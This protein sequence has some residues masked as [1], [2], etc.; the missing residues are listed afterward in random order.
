[1]PPPLPLPP[2]PSPA[3]SVLDLDLVVS[4]SVGGVSYNV[5]YSNTP[6]RGLVH[7]GDNMDT[8]LEGESAEWPAGGTLDAATY[9]VCVQA[10][11]PEPGQRY[12]I[13]LRVVKDG[14]D[15]LRLARAV[16]PTT[17]TGGD[18][19]PS[20]LDYY[21]SYT[22]AASG[23]TPAGVAPLRFVANWTLFSVPLPPSPPPSP[24]E[25]P[26][27]PPAP[28]IPPDQPMTAS[29]PEPPRPSPKPP[30]PLPPS[31]QPGPPPSPLPP[32]P[33]MPPPLPLPPLPS[34]AV[35]VLDL[36]LVVSWS[37]GGVSYN[38]S[39]S[40]TP[41]RGLVHGGDNMDTG[42]EGESA[43]WPAGGT[44]DA[45]AYHVCVQA[46][47]PEP[48][49]RYNITLRVVKDGVDA[50]SLARAVVPTTTT[51]GDC[52]PSS[53]DY[54]A[55]YTYAA[56]GSTPAGVA[57]LRFVANW[58]LFSVPLPPS[59]PPSPPEP[60]TS[61]PAPP[62]P[63]DQ[64][65]LARPPEPPRPSPKPPLPTPPTPLP[66][67]AFDL[68]IWVAWNASG[69]QYDVNLN[70]DPPAGV[71][72]GDDSKITGNSSESVSWVTATP[73]NAQYRV[74]VIEYGGSA[75]RLYNVTLTASRSGSVVLQTWA[76]VDSTGTP[77]RDCLPG[78][79]GYI[80]SYDFTPPASPSPPYLVL[81]VS[82]TTV[83]RPPP[84][85]APPSPRPSPP[86]APPRPP[87]APSVPGTWQPPPPLAPA[88]P[89]ADLD[90]V[91][92]WVSGGVAY[93]I[94]WQ[95]PSLQGGVLVSN[96]SAANV[97]SVT[98]P[99]ASQPD[100]ATY[101]VCVTSFDNTTGALLSVYLSVAQ[102]GA[103]RLA[104][105]VTTGNLSASLAACQPGVPGYVGS[106]NHTYNPSVSLQSP[107]PRLQIAINWASYQATAFDV[108]IWV[109]WNASGSQYDVNLNFDPPAGVM[110]S[111]DSNITGNSSESVSWVTATPDN[112]QYRVCVIEYGGSAGRLYNVTLT[113]SRSGSVVLQT[114]ALVDS[115]GTPARDCLPG[116]FGYIGSYDFTPPASPSPPYLVLSVSWTTVLRPPPSPAPPSPRPSPPLA[117]PRPPPAPSV[118]G[119]WQPPP[120]LAPAGPTADLDL[121]VSWV[122]GGVAYNITWQQPSLQGGVLVSNGS[123]ANVESVT[124]PT[125]SQPD[126]AT[127][128]VCVT[129]FD[130]TTGALLSVYLSVAQE[131]AS[132]LATVVTTGNLSA[133]LAACQPGVPGYVGSYNH[134]YNP[135]VSLQSPAPRLQIAINWAS[136]QEFLLDL[137]L[138]VAWAA[139]GAPFLL[140]YR[141]G[142]LRGFVHGG[143]N[144]AL[145]QW[146][147]QPVQRF[148]VTLRVEVDGAVAQA[149]SRTMGQVSTNSSSCSPS[150]LDYYASYTYAASG[151]TPAGVAPLRFVAN[152][153]L[154]SVPL[155]PSPPPSPPEPPTSPPAPPIPPDQPMTAKPPVPVADLDIWVAWD[156][157]GFPHSV[158]TAYGTEGGAVLSDDSRVTGNSTESV[159]WD[160]VTPDAALYHVCV[161]DFGGSSGTLYNVTLSVTKAGS[162][163]QQT[164]AQVDSTGAVSSSCAPGQFGYVGSYDYA[165][166]ASPTTPRFQLTVSWTTDLRSG[167]TADLD[168]VV[169]WVSGGVAYNITWQQPSL[170]G[171]VLVS[172]GSAANVE[173]VTWPTAS[174][175]DSAT[176]HV[177]VTSFDNTTGALLS[178]YLSVAQE[179]ASRLATVVTTGN[180][181]ASLAVCQPGVPGYVGSYS[182][183]YNPSVSLQSPAP[184]LQIAINWASYQAS[185][186]AAALPTAFTTNPPPPR[187]PAP[188]AAPTPPASLTC[189][190][191]YLGSGDASLDCTGDSEP[192]VEVGGGLK[193]FRSSGVALVTRT[194][195]TAY[196]RYQ[197]ATGQP[198][199]PPSRFL[200]WGITFRNV[201]HLRL[202]N[203]AIANLRL[204]TGGPLLQCINCPYLTF[205]NVTL[206]ALSGFPADQYAASAFY[207]NG[208][209]WGQPSLLYE[210][211]PYP[212]DTVFGPLHASNVTSAQLTGFTCADVQ[213]SHGW[214]CLL[215]QAGPGQQA[216]SLS[217][218]ASSVRDTSVVWGGAYGTI[219]ELSPEAAR[220]GNAQGR[221]VG[222]GAVV[223]DGSGN[224]LAKALSVRDTSIRGAA[225][226]HGAAFALLAAH[227]D[228]VTLAN[229]SASLGRAQGSGGL[230]FA[231]GPVDLVAASRVALI[232]NSA[233][234]NP[235]LAGRGGA[236]C[237]A[238]LL[239]ALSAEDSRLDGNAGAHGGALY[240]GDLGAGSLRNCSLS[241]NAASVSGGALFV[242]ASAGSGSVS[243]SLT[244]CSLA[245]NV[246]DNGDGGAFY[247]GAGA[248]VSAVG[249]RITGNIAGRSGGALFCAGR[250]GSLVL[251]AA[252]A[253][254]GNT[255]WG[256][257]GG[258]A[259]A[260]E[261][262]V[263]L[264]NSSCISD[265]R[266]GGSGGGLHVDGNLTLSVSGCLNNNTAGASGGAV[267]LGAGR[268]D[269]A[270]GSTLADNSATLD[271]G[272][273]FSVGTLEALSL[274][275]CSVSGNRAGGSGGVV[276]GS[277]NATVAVSALSE[278]TANEAGSHGG[279]LSVA[280]H[281]A[282]TLAA[283]T[284]F[285]NRAGGSGGAIQCGPGP[286]SLALSDASS[287]NSNTAGLHGGA[288]F[289]T[290]PILSVGLEGA[291]R[292]SGNIAG[293]NGG[294]LYAGA[295]LT[296]ASLAGQS[297]LSTNQAAGDGGA[298]FVVGELSLE[299]SDGSTA[300]TNSAGGS[301]GVLA[302]GDGPTSISISAGSSLSSNAA[303]MKGGAVY[304]SGPVDSLLVTASRIT[305]NQAGD[306]GGAVYAGAGIRSAAL[307]AAAE[308]S[309]NRAARSGG[310][311]YSQGPL[312]VSVDGSRVSFNT[313][314]GSGGAIAVLGGP[315]SLTLAASSNLTDNVASI[316]G[317]ALYAGRV[318]L[319]SLM[320]SRLA[321]NRAN[322]SGG[323]VYTNQGLNSVALA[324]GSAM[325]ANTA[326][327]DGG[328]LY[329]ERDLQQLSVTEGS[330][331]GSN[332]AGRGGGALFVGGTAQ[333]LSILT[334]SRLLNNSAGRNGGLLH[335]QDGVAEL[336]LERNASLSGNR[337]GGD[338]GALFTYGALGLLALSQSSITANQ[339]AGSGGAVF[340]ALGVS[341]VSANA[342]SAIAN[343]TASVDGGA[344]FGGRNC[345]LALLG[346]SA[347][348]GNSAGRSGG[349]LYV[350]GTLTA[351]TLQDSSLRGNTAQRSGGVL[352]IQDG[353][354][355]LSV[356]LGTA[357]EANSARR[358]G[359]ANC[360]GDVGTVT[361]NGSSLARNQATGGA[362]GVF[363]VGGAFA[364]LELSGGSSLA[365]NVA[366]GDGGVAWVGGA[367]GTLSLDASSVQGNV[368]TKG[369]GGGVTALGPITQILVRGLSSVQG[370]RAGSFGGFACAQGGLDSFA[371]EGASQLR[372]NAAGASGGALMATTLRSVS[373]LGQSGF[374]DNTASSAGGAIYVDGNVTGEVRLAGGSFFRGNKAHAGGAVY[375]GGR[376]TRLR[377][378]GLS[379]AD[380]NTAVTEGGAIYAAAL[381][382]LSMSQSWMLLNSAGRSGGG[383]WAEAV[384]N[385]TMSDSTLRANNA[386]AGN[387]GA[388][389]AS[390]LT[391][392]TLTSGS[393]IADNSAGSSGGGMWLGLP[394]DGAAQWALDA[395]SIANNT[396]S[397]GSGGG[398]FVGA[399]TTATSAWSVGLSSIAITNNSA[400][401]DGGALALAWLGTAGQSS[402]LLAVRGCTFDQNRCEGRGGALALH[403]GAVEVTSTAFTANQAGSNGGALFAAMGAASGG[404]SPGWVVPDRSSPG[405]A[406]DCA[407]FVRQQA[408]L[409]SPQGLTSGPPV[410]V[411][412]SCFDGNAAVE[413]G[414]SV[415]LQY[416]GEAA[417][418]DTVAWVVNSLLQ[419]NT[420]GTSGGALA[421]LGSD[422]GAGS[423][424]PM[425]RRR[426]LAAGESASLRLLGLVVSGNTAS[427]GSGGG[428]YL[429]GPLL[430][431]Q[432]GQSAVTGNSAGSGGGLSAVE[433]SLLT[434]GNTTLS[435]NKASSYGGALYLA[436]AA[437]LDLEALAV[438]GNT[439]GAGGGA[440]ILGTGEQLPANRTT[441]LLLSTASFANNTASAAASPSTSL[442]F[443]G[444][445]GAVFLGR[446][447][448]AALVGVDVGTGNTASAAGPGIASLQDMS[449]CAGNA[450]SGTGQSGGSS[451]SAS[452]PSTWGALQQ[453]TR[454]GC[455]PLAL[456]DLR[457]LSSQG[458]ISLN[459][460]NASAANSSLIWVRDAAASSLWIRCSNA[461]NSTAPT[462]SP[463]PPPPASALASSSAL[464]A[465][466]SD[467][468]L[469]SLAGGNDTATELDTVSRLAAGLATCQLTYGPM[470]DGGSIGG[471]VSLRPAA[472]RLLLPDGLP[473]P[474]GAL[475]QAEP[476]APVR[477][478]LE[479]VTAAGIR[480]TDH[481]PISVQLSLSPEGLA[482]ADASPVFNPFINGLATWEAARFAGWSGS[483]Y[484]LTFRPVYLA[485]AALLSTARSAVPPLVFPMTL[486]PCSMG[487][488]VNV[489]STPLIAALTVC[490]L[491]GP[492]QFTLWQDPR[493]ASEAAVASVLDGPLRAQVLAGNGTCAACPADAY[494]AGGAV[495]A[496]LRGWWHSAPNSTL[497]HR[498]FN[499]Q[500][501][502]PDAASLSPALQED[503]A[504]AEQAGG[505]G[506][507]GP[508]VACQQEW[509]ASQPPGS[510]ALAAYSSASANSTGGA[511]AMC[512][513][514]G[515]P[516]DS[517]VSYMQRQC[518]PGYAGN[519]CATCEPGFKRS[520]GYE[521]TAC[522]GEGAT[523]VPMTLAFLATV[524][525]VLG[526][527][528]LALFETAAR[529]ATEVNAVDAVKMVVLHMQLFVILTRLPLGWPDYIHGFQAFMGAWTGAA[530]VFTFQSACLVS[531]ASAEIQTRAE[532][533][534]GLF[535]AVFAAVLALLL[536]A[537]RS[538]VVSRRKKWEPQGPMRN[539][540]S[541]AV[542]E[543]TSD[544]GEEAEAS[545]GSV[546]R[547]RKKPYSM[548]P[549]PLPEA[550]PMPQSDA[551]RAGTPPRMLRPG[552]FRRLRSL[553]RR[554]SNT[555]PAPDTEAPMSAAPP[556]MSRPSSASVFKDSSL[557]LRQQLA[558]VAL[559]AAF[560]LYPALMQVTLSIFAC[561]TLD[562][563]EGQY[564]AMQQATWSDGYWILDM[565]M[566]CFTSV[567][568]SRYVPLGAVC[569][570]L[571]VAAPTLVLMGLLWSKRRLLAEQG[572]LD[573]HG[574]LYRCY[575]PQLF[576][577]ACV[578]QVEL[579]SLVIVELFGRNMAPYHQGLLF[580]CLLLALALANMAAAPE[581]PWPLAAAEGLSLGVLA[582]SV[583]M[584]L[585]F[586]DTG[587]AQM[588]LDN[589]AAEDAIGALIILFNITVLLALLG[590][591][592][593]AFRGKRSPVLSF[594]APS[595]LQQLGSVVLISAE[596]PATRGAL[597]ASPTAEH[598]EDAWAAAHSPSPQPRPSTPGH[599]P[600]VDPKEV[601]AALRT[602]YAGGGGASR[603]PTADAGMRSGRNTP[604]MRLS[605]PGQVDQEQLVDV[606][607][608]AH[609]EAQAPALAA[610]APRRETQV[611]PLPADYEQRPSS[612]RTS[613][614]GSGSPWAAGPMRLPASRQGTMSRF[615]EMRTSEVGMH[616]PP[617]LQPQASPNATE[618]SGRISPS[619]PVSGPQA[620]EYRP[621]TAAPAFTVG[622]PTPAPPR[623]LTAPDP[624]AAE[625]EAAG[626][627]MRARS[628]DDLAEAPT[629]DPR[630]HSTTVMAMEA[631]P[632]HSGP[633]S[634]V[635]VQAFPAAASSP[636][637]R[638]SSAAPS[639]PESAHAP[640][641]AWT[642]GAPPVNR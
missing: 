544:P 361:I 57:P 96:G 261:A 203:S 171:G 143:D 27:S 105:V 639:R 529:T 208:S 10:W 487:S 262:T 212:Q 384:E 51:G 145:R 169:S 52:S 455:W 138:V 259:H 489:S 429:F 590:L 108:D 158:S 276:Y 63:P 219:A 254:S 215:L 500:A 599:M 252:S 30:V 358:G 256:G 541:G 307:T 372:D 390:A 49:Q 151:S 149:S 295:G 431:A 397:R 567:H 631:N 165:P 622:G 194:A 278:V 380:G 8:G 204:S 187:P 566:E 350:G 486:E 357:I 505:S 248:T 362:G 144:M 235:L 630:S 498:C 300:S 371:L 6:V 183:T 337:A 572:T 325:E 488:Q 552:T 515:V 291:S 115:T 94:T 271:G 241:G 338:G 188:P 273:V 439:A 641:S 310:A 536:W 13:T 220:G 29:P 225:G 621:S 467:L 209:A 198:Q 222:Y 502:S 270:P 483:G 506:V 110:L 335:A 117:P 200:D 479:L 563:G 468:V 3:V 570:I 591:A 336:T 324:G 363:W 25:P 528:W 172:N 62:I 409:C 517:P 46:W 378:E 191:L 167:P 223:F 91:V 38:V 413:A 504:A 466:V 565:N 376:L 19:S 266:A 435:G 522:E 375:V 638:P 450:T 460:S 608:A 426:L 279:V 59:P 551:T 154:F 48:G 199:P 365:G 227:S 152:W 637:I 250:L 170:Q 558:V 545:G 386:T 296:K 97:E 101:H 135:S 534:G 392:W 441:V 581:R 628:A 554:H 548:T 456:Y 495:V 633:S 289:A 147:P 400:A 418:P 327:L 340:A 537:V 130:N 178:V 113:A 464:D 286:L 31:P 377:F 21:A 359:F 385:L 369:A 555:A 196:P 82:W 232:N 251:R 619:S 45:A 312:N 150:S 485:S 218:Q 503:A 509:Y 231:D 474:A 160:A 61:P 162:L 447:V 14:V 134:T 322:G 344:L 424:T 202:V 493:N 347:L 4:W 34:P 36:D 1:M 283:S 43:E 596:A 458:F 192:T 229:V 230:L 118:P 83:L 635:Q 354:Q 164:W 549:P 288:V 394:A 292:V 442:P 24:P 15:A 64:P 269:L 411:C 602:S 406:Q 401:M 514:W 181:S 414:G 112:A 603:P 557:T 497:M 122:S 425:R 155:P 111:D 616:D 343:N 207:V 477:V 238:G 415:Y 68:D 258:A 592:V 559:V 41:V 446:S 607:E 404:Q 161:I 267:Y 75:G 214:A 341:S 139:G 496:P 632:S 636:E 264:F 86:L 299:L 433:V 236:I 586:V 294:A 519:L 285:G 195:A 257:S 634:R 318:V 74:C 518:A 70:F 317:G 472:M 274:S 625:Q 132:R 305:N 421:L 28:P 176:Y 396:A 600:W 626:A 76:L 547:V 587:S 311:L 210:A 303:V 40:N 137:D 342:S 221:L 237:V 35:S 253:L 422:S 32:V 73:D 136:Y 355:L 78:Q 387:G 211:T 393:I 576:F 368:A 611:M 260:S 309:A 189:T 104:T 604:K 185:P 516:D 99:T 366:D 575:R 190:L 298:L 26:T 507:S 353:V 594:E 114:W 2:L 577:W 53:L 88:G 412:G 153:T 627:W 268:I 430:S 243:L 459:P 610:L 349:A 525:T 410:A 37:V 179:G 42:L 293:S 481:E 244:S 334:G 620:A 531:D 315:L 216:P 584:G 66:P 436:G 470:T 302:A 339:A 281:L 403:A 588:D 420:A 593:W 5:S 370:N 120:P 287:L 297:E 217:V 323:A 623:P 382:E 245:S 427:A 582:L 408:S 213:A 595:G 613:S 275:A 228:S 438:A 50:L 247:T 383:V 399:P 93:N 367:L 173:S 174:Q 617:H 98:W 444:H 79:F 510:S 284:L 175:P 226:G 532:L 71:M 184:R 87:P 156:T 484:S 642:Q 301:G 480:V 146:G 452:W 272:A 542:A 612:R 579:L 107:A 65:M 140:S 263:Q 543:A 530:N 255:A 129:S 381:G 598:P 475:V 345:S 580:L 20:S 90:L 351:V 535:W 22:Y 330:L 569:I 561:H 568:N 7:G 109:A 67:T 168:L 471:L 490:D 423:T 356:F 443:D 141:T 166:A 119:T 44:P 614:P 453:A 437:Q 11:N 328:A 54:Y 583:A 331:I 148:N 124:W 18:C 482:L 546:R 265:N 9:H 556:N 39:Y 201:T 597:A 92:S 16:V 533:L 58:T 316:D 521:C 186:A 313:A 125:A 321:A 69:S 246:A 157:N 609:E 501:C 127:Y 282:L 142:P 333:R 539:S 234:A 33:P 434:L 85:P 478:R 571:F 239:D 126:S 476:G 249:T 197:S 116:Q 326:G 332:S 395:S 106:Y 319:L 314:Q 448:A 177:C 17:T 578:V 206:S 618:L 499:P 513:L 527:A 12:N 100:S 242:N 290:G 523:A 182:H 128:H 23:S 103:S 524:A 417:S 388:I 72:L 473:A 457:P 494:C 329:C 402:G 526:L 605:T 81:S 405:T 465:A 407:S 308:V 131:G 95:Q 364:T 492:Q 445:G 163:M 77:A 550:A 280:G 562:S 47:N 320:A 180:L 233:G 462:A 80:G 133:S 123:A 306:S 373:V 451:A 416:T 60:P 121:V 640:E 601:Q 391:R 89:T 560:V 419:G 56:S 573:T 512:L 348:S 346:R 440:Y 389:A 277:G 454:T 508:L 585:Y 449:D 553:L 102:E 55:S 374:T 540:E 491:C 538:W 606:P 352:F 463:P 629:F 520:V 615:A 360:E 379:S 398:L 193:P 428:L 240:A 159:T 574:W 432:L 564:G 304:A 469:Q 624:N 224:P 589:G 205:E 84:S 511:G 461:T